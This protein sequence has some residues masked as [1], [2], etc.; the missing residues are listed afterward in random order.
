MADRE[1]LRR[2]YSYGPIP[3]WELDRLAAET[4][5][6]QAAV[7]AETPKPRRGRPPKPRA[8]DTDGDAD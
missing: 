2:K 8:E 4:E 5:A 6:A 7:R 1:A 3:Q